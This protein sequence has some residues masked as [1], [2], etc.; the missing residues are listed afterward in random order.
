MEKSYYLVIKCIKV[1]LTIEPLLKLVE[2]VAALGQQ[3][4]HLGDDGF[5]GHIVGFE[6]AEA[7]LDPLSDLVN[8][9]VAALV[10]DLGGQ[11]QN[12]AGLVVVAQTLGKGVHQPLGDAADAKT[13]HNNA[14]VLFKDGRDEFRAKDLDR[15]SVV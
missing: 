3:P 12:F 15:K 4:H 11:D 9:H 8:A 2:T 1:D 14:V 7:V 6:E 10:G 5:N 13:F